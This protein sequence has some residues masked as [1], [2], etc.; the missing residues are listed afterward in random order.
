MPTPRK[1][2]TNADFLIIG[3]GIAGLGALAEARGLGIDAI[4]LEAQSR[5]GGRIRTVR[6]KRLAQYPI[7]L[8]AEFV[9]GSAMKK[10]CE[11]LGLSLVKH[12]SDGACGKLSANGLSLTWCS[13]PSTA[14]S[15]S[16][17][18]WAGAAQACAV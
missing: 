13:A 12:P 16:A 17:R 4:C 15:P 14:P 10:L 5:P 6:N 1:L 8:G 18:S 9:H 7:E 3:G 11:S 2:R